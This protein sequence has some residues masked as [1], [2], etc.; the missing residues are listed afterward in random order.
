MN[1]FE[2]MANAGLSLVKSKIDID[3]LYSKVKDSDI[4]SLLMRQLTGIVSNKTELSMQAI[5]PNENSDLEQASTL[6]IFVW[7]CIVFTSSFV[8]FWLIPN[9]ATIYLQ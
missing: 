4:D 9:L 7:T 3:G 2:A 6:N 5:V 1:K 8:L